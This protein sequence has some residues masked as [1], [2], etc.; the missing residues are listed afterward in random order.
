MTYAL[1][2]LGYLWAAPVT[3]VGLVLALVGVIT[4][5]RLRCQEWGGGQGR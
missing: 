2:L 3:A 5:G 4:G 1:R